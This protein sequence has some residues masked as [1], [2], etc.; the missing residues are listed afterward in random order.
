MKKL[1]SIVA[2]TALLTTGAM[3]GAGDLIVNGT[4]QA[5]TEVQIGTGVAGGLTGGNN[6]QESI[7]DMGDLALGTDNKK[8]FNVY[9]STNTKGIVT[10]KFTPVPLKTSSNMALADTKY[11]FTADVA[12]G[13]VSNPAISAGDEIQISNN[14]MKNNKVVG[15]LDVTATTAAAQL[16]GEYKATMAVTVTAAI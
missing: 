1:L 14:S 10:M 9:V 4:I 6:F 13:A 16:A 15:T 5:A 8:S 7:V 3:A 2:T 11:A 12:Q